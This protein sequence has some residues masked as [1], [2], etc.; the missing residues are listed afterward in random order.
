M[1]FSLLT[2]NGKKPKPK[3]AKEDIKVYK[4]ITEGGWGWM[5]NLHIN[6]KEEP[7][8]KGFRYIE[9]TP[10]KDSRMSLFNTKLFKVNG[11]AFHSKKTQRA[12][13]DIRNVAEKIVEMYIPKNAIYYENNTEYVSSEIVWYND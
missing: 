5:N 9:T 12:A 7:W 4:V 3:K 1:C 10:F 6:G 11:N 2:D 13:F 8:T